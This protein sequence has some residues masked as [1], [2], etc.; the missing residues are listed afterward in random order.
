M[1]SIIGNA[2]RDSVTRFLTF[3]FFLIKQPP[4]GPDSRAKKPFEILLRIREDSRFLI[5][6]Y[7]ACG[8]NATE[9]T[10]TVC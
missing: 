5:A 10:K 4:L 6:D 1:A 7:H 2:F 3:V 8:V 9:C